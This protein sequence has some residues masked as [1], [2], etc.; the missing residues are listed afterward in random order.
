MAT[1]GERWALLYR[2][3]EDIGVNRSALVKQLELEGQI[4]VQKEGGRQ[5]I[6]PQPSL[7]VFMEGR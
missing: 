3:A 2:A 4:V 6:Y 5:V 7:L 1:N